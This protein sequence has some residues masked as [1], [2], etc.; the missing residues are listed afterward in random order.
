MNGGG[1]PPVFVVAPNADGGLSISYKKTAPCSHLLGI[2]QEISC[3]VAG[4]CRGEPLCSPLHTGQAQGP[5]P[6]TVGP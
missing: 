6:T 1:K 5:A 4:Y 3:P 2:E